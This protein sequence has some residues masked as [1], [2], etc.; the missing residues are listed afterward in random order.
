MRGAWRAVAG[1]LTDLYYYG[2]N[3]DRRVSQVQIYPTERSLPLITVHHCAATSL[4]V[5]SYLS[6]RLHSSP[7]QKSKYH[8]LPNQ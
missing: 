2:S 5:P 8:S 6:I 7:T 3:I 1:T 4:I